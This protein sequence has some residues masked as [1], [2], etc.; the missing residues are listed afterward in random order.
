MLGTSWVSVRVHS[1]VEEEKQDMVGCKGEE[2]NNMDLYMVAYI[3][4]QHT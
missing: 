2:G 3:E 1:W 4:V